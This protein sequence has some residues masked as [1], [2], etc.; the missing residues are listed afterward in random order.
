[1][2]IFQGKKTYNTKWHHLNWVTLNIGRRGVGTFKETIIE[3]LKLSQYNRKTCNFYLK[4]KE[5]L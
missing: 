3:P 2:K 4:V 1:M 5:N